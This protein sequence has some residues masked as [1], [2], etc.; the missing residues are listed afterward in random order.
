[1]VDNTTFTRE[2]NTDIK[3]VLHLCAQTSEANKESSNIC[4]EGGT[5]LGPRFKQYQK[6]LAKQALHERKQSSISCAAL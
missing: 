2:F 6:Q 5:P 3:V 1:M 4:L